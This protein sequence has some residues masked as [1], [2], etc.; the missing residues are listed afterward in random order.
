MYRG[1]LSAANK[2]EIENIKDSFVELA[3]KEE[4]ETM[5]RVLANMENR[6]ID[7]VNAD[8]T[9]P[10]S[11]EEIMRGLNQMHPL[12]SPDPDGILGFEVVA[13]NEK[14]SSAP[15]SGG[16]IEE[17]GRGGLDFWP[18]KENY[19][20][21]QSEGVLVGNDYQ[22]AINPT[23]SLFIRWEWFFHQYALGLCSLNRLGVEDGFRCCRPAFWYFNYNQDGAPDDGTRSCPTNVGPSSYYSGTPYDYVLGLADQFHNVM[24][25]AEQSL[26]NYSIADLVNIKDEGYIFE[27]IYDRISQW[28]D[29]ILPRYHTLSL[30][31]YSTK[32]LIRDLSLP[33]EKID[34][35]KNGCML[36][37]KDDINLDY[38]KFCGDARYK[39][40][41]EQNSNRKK[42][43]YAI[44]RYLPLTPRLQRLL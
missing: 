7:T 37:W 13:K 16:S 18:L 15:D 27:R 2:L 32:N 36:Y 44:L 11:L 42:T 3:S 31:Y 22:K 1:D 26:W 33:V 39:L 40:T 8:L 19:V 6:A 43:P 30:D 34:T 23:V 29:L 41:R 20:A 4:K 35:C 21:L 25:V 38:Y 12:K 9:R 24:H 17:G 28:A 10:F 14:I 5:E